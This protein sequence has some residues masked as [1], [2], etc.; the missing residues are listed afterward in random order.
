MF[1][2]FITDIARRLLVGFK[3]D[4]KF[5][6]IDPQK[7]KIPEIK[8]SGLYI[9]IP[10]CK[11]MCF[12]CPYNKVRYDR[13]LIPPYIQ[14]LL[15][16]I[17]LYAQKLGKIKI[18]SI[19]IGGGTPTNII[20]ELEIVLEKIR[21]EFEVNG[22]IAV[23]TTVAD[24][25][26]YAVKKLKLYGVNLISL[27]VQ[28]FSDKYLKMLGRN[29]NSEEIM[30]AIQ[31]LKSAGFD[32]INI[33]LMFCLPSQTKEEIIDDLKKAIKS[34]A[35][36][37]T[38]YPLFTFPYSS[39][40]EHK[41]IKKVK[42]PNIFLRRKFYGLMHEFLLKNGFNKISVWGFQK[43]KKQKYSSVTRRYYIGLGAG[44]GSSFSDK[45]YFNTFSI[46]A[47]NERL[48]NNSLPVAVSMNISKMLACYYWLYWKFY[49]T[50]FKREELKQVFGN[51]WKVGFL[52]KLLKL[53][54]FCAFS[55]N[56][57]ELTEKGSFWIH[58]AQNYFVL[59]YINKV[60]ST[61]KKKD[62]PDIIKF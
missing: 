52:I 36:Q 50:S 1:I 14:S 2:K 44:A 55:K 33:D 20:D 43:I 39:I 22:D 24:I 9:H 29:Y 49:D 32:T 23:E 51:H 60:W 6:K 26:E 30:P 37:I 3:T 56:K 61:M 17:E 57:I 27:G 46:D 31:K 21:K 42:M 48:S 35:D 38:L 12:Y 15:R 8:E 16:E 34:G 11:S 19:Y 18:S 40:G 59:N 13:K 7:F 25:N 45:F 53:L 47:Y 58:L 28:S 10:F 62:F 5:K 41:K 4:F 54:N